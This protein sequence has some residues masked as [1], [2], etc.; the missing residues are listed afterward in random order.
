ML[1]LLLVFILIVVL[2]IVAFVAWKLDLLFQ[3]NHPIDPKSKSNGG[4]I[5]SKVL[6]AHG[7]EFIYTL[8][9]GHV[10]PIFVGCENEGIRVIDT[11]HEVTAAFAADAT[12]RLT[13]NIGVA[14]VTAGPGV[15]NTITAM[16]NAQMAESPVLLIGGA[17]ATIAKGRGAL[18]DIEQLAVLKTICKHSASITRIRDIAPTLRKAIQIAK[19]GCPGPVFVEMPIDIL[20]P[21]ELVLR[22]AVGGMQPK[23]IVQ[24]LV[25]WYLHKHVGRIFAGGFDKADYDPLPVDIPMASPSEVDQVTELLLKSKKPVFVFGSQIV[26]PP[27]PLDQVGSAVEN[28][29][30]P[31]FLGGMSRGLL[32]ADSK[33]QCRHCRKGALKD[34]DFVLLA[35]TVCDFR[36]SYGRSLPKKAT[37]IAVNR[38]KSQLE[39]NKTVMWHPTKLIKADPSSFLLDLSKKLG[40]YVA[41]DSWLKRWKEADAKREAEIAQK[42]T[43]EVDKG[44]N[45][46]SL[47]K[48]FDGILGPKSIL[49]ADGGDFVGTAAYTV[50]PTAPLGW[51]DPGAFGTLGVGA[52]FALGA[53]LC[54]PDA[55]VWVVFGDGSLGYS[56]AE[57]DTFVRF[58]IPIMAVVG[59]DA[60]WSQIYREQ[61]VLFKSDVACRL[62]F[63][64]YHKAIEAL[65]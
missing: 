59:N 8:C 1:G 26:L 18:Q 61:S 15:T 36:L 43:A 4:D 63:T 47:L 40:K 39:L 33:V 46:I 28:M 6:K 27:A 53:K 16:K 29:G 65:G 41:D 14:V 9:G 17:A 51:L 10:S 45:P 42:A 58:K 57:F 64:D 31:T 3:L 24:K 19:S 30:I 38:S 20:Y 21:Y 32:G 5:V 37:I 49:V 52:G 25:L 50:R 2:L 56:L 22:E 12:A 35:G 7:V 11:R 62:A 60:C 48:T 55:D 23:S 13:R 44:L 34:A 54:R